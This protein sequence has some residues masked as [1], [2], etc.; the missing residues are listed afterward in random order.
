MSP[1]LETVPL[2]P[3]SAMDTQTIIDAGTAATI[4]DSCVLRASK[5]ADCPPAACESGP[6]LN[7]AE[8]YDTEAGEYYC[9]CTADYAGANCQTLIIS[10]TGRQFTTD[11]DAGTAFAPDGW[12]YLAVRMGPDYFTADSVLDVSTDTG[13][14]TG[15]DFAVFVRHGD[16]PSA[17][18]FDARYPDPRYLVP[19]TTGAAETCLPQD[20]GI[21]E[22]VAL[23]GTID[24]SGTVEETDR[25][26]CEGAGDGSNCVYTA[27]AA[28]TNDTWAV[29]PAKPSTT[30]L[31]DY[32]ASFNPFSAREGD[33]WY[34]GI[35]SAPACTYT[36]GDES[37]CLDTPGCA[38]TA[39]VAEVAE[40]CVDVDGSGDDC[41]GFSAG[42]ASSCGDCDYTAPVAGVAEACSADTTGV[43]FDLVLTKP[44][45]PMFSPAPGL[46][47]GPVEVCV[48][49]PTY[50]E[51][52]MTGLKE[53]QRNWPARHMYY[54][55]LPYSD[56]AQPKLSGADG[57]TDS[58]DNLQL[59]DRNGLYSTL[60]GQTESDVFCWN[61]EPPID[62]C[63]FYPCQHNATCT[64]T[65]PTLVEKHRGV[66]SNYTCTC[67][68]NYVGVHCQTP[69]V[70]LDDSG[71]LSVELDEVERGWAYVAVVSPTEDEYRP[72]Y[73]MNVTVEG[74]P[75][76][77]YAREGGHPLSE[78]FDSRYPMANESAFTAS[79]VD[80]PFNPFRPNA[81]NWYIGVHIPFH[82]P[83]A[84]VG[85]GWCNSSSSCVPQ[86][87]Y[88]PWGCDPGAA[89]IHDAAIA[90]ECPTPDNGGT[91]DDQADCW[92]QFAAPTVRI[93]FGIPPEVRQCQPHLSQLVCLT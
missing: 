1:T 56:S 13:T 59:L 69:L 80:A 41:T 66:P 39:A 79:F 14:T 19:G 11:I 42:D 51:I 93:G 84:A 86:A 31:L 55:V 74:F 62:P 37:S 76:A 63:D 68:G 28:Q 26:A 73:V 22:D 35:Y 85:M 82:D 32:R 40:A 60:L 48:T 52:D 33:L 3:G 61:Q 7:D 29:D 27:F 47:S 43:V 16:F 21:P 25:S 12:T 24:L 89:R 46:M 81:L 9:V 23:C 75:F 20:A 18:S 15:V 77:V 83:C 8:C 2:A 87:H 67:W 34:V 72:S 71:Q 78:S 44:L 54:I 65:L 90:S 92:V 53:E 6:C 4:G 50:P 64:S 36:T 58:C 88:G 57:E 45:E 91:P 70:E 17:E 30:T 5:I 49:A 10:M 38:Y